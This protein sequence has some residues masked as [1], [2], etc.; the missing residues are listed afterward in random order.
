[1]KID[2][3]SASKVAKMLSL[4]VKIENTSSDN[5]FG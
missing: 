3:K 1:M 5:S 2:T 4:S